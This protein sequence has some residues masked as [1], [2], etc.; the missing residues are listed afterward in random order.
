MKYDL[1]AVDGRAYA[2]RITDVTRNDLYFLIERRGIQPSAGPEG[3]IENEGPYVIALAGE[4]LHQ[5]GA[6]EAIRSSDQNFLVLKHH[7]LTFGPRAGAPRAR[8]S[9]IRILRVLFSGTGPSR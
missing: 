7:R 9:A 6:D 2:L 8:A 3:V 1:T 5:M 4:V